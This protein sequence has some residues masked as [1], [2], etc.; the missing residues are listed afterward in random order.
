MSTRLGQRGFDIL[1]AMDEQVARR[2]LE[3]AIQERAETKQAVAEAEELDAVRRRR[4]YEVIRQVIR[5]N[6][7]LRQVDIVRMTGWTRKYIRDIETGKQN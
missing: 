4:I 5:P 6:G 3:Q 1:A 7:P 2:L